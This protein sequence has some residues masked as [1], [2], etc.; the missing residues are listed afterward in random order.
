MQ[1]KSLDW[2]VRDAKFIE[3]AADETVREVM[4]KLSVILCDAAR[5]V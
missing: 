3:K 1:V 2:Q 4:A 5:C